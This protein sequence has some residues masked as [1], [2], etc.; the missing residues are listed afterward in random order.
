VLYGDQKG[1][2]NGSGS[3]TILSRVDETSSLRIINASSSPPGLLLIGPDINNR[4]KIGLQRF[5]I[6]YR[7]R[8]RLGCVEFCIQMSQLL[9]KGP[10][11]GFLQWHHSDC[12]D[13][14][15]QT[16]SGSW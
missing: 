14:H 11:S 16:R 9:E 6:L 10:L 3:Q 12:L 7:G 2:I 15:Q 8:H 5:L 4:H 1:L 13:L